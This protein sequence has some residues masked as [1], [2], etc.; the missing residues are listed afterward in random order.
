MTEDDADASIVRPTISLAHALGLRVVVEGVE[1]QR[2]WD[3]LAAMECDTAQGYYI[4]RPLPPDAIERW[5]R[6]APLAA[7]VCH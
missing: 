5:V 2:T 3:A 4:S 7:V 6:T 1:D